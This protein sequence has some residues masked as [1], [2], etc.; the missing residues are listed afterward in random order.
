MP[1]SNRVVLDAGP[2]IH[3]LLELLDEGRP[4]GVL[5]VSQDEARTPKREQRQARRI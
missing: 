3:P 2:F 1:L 5:L 4:A